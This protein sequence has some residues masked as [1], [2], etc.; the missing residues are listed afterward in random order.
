MSEQSLK[1]EIQQAVKEAMRAKDKERLVVL[2]SILAEFKQVE[3][4]KRIELDRT[5]ELAILDSMEKQ[6]KDAMAQ[7][8][9]ANR[10]D[11]A[12]K[13][14][15]ELE[16]IKGFKPPEMSDDEIAAEISAAIE[17]TGAAGVKDMG[18]VMAILKPKLQGRADLGKASSLVK[19]QLDA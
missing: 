16:I 9:D 5:S 15:Y 7:F 1:S 14:Q 2:R 19:Q 17:S 10:E 3:V 6:R 8:K 18:K 12:D 11:L 4:D 13:E